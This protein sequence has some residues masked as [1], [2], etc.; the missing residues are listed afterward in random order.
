MSRDITT[1]AKNATLADDVIEV[2]LVKMEFGSGTS[3]VTTADRTI[4]YD[5]N[6]YLGVGG[7]GSISPISENGQLNPEKV[8]LSLSGV[9]SAN[10]ATA[11]GEDYQGL[12]ATIYAGYFNI[13]TYAL[14]A[15][16][17]ILFKGTMD[18]MEVILGK[19]ANIKVSVISILDNWRK[20]KIRRYNNDDQQSEYLGDK[21]FEYVEQIAQGKKLELIL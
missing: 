16:P 3:Y 17:V 12:P 20:P 9:D 8:E 5:S 2:F 13:S 1:A 10:I 4:T 14:I 11:L 6:N 21:G 19:T 15:D 18:N 7:L